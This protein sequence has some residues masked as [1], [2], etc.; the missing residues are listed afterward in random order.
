MKRL[1]VLLLFGMALQSWAVPQLINYQGLLTRPDGSSLDTVVA[2]TFKLYGASSG[3][4]ALWTET[5]PS[6]TVRVGL[7]NALLG[8]GASIPDSFHHSEIWLGITVGDNSEMTP[9]SRIVSV[10]YSYRVGTVDGANGGTISGD[11]N[12]SGKANIGSGNANP[13]SYAFVAGENNTTSGPYTT[14]AG[15]QDNNATGTSSVVGGGSFNRSRGNYSVVAGG[16]GSTAQDSNSASGWNSTIGGGDRNVALG[17]GST[18]DG[19]TT[20]AAWGDY[21]SVGGGMTN[22]AE[23]L[24]STVG[25][26]S[27]NLAKADYATIPGGRGN[28]ATGVGSTV[29]GGCINYA[30]GGYSVVAGGGGADYPDSNSAVG[31]YSTVGG[32]RGNTASSDYATVGGGDNNYAGNDGATI[33]GGRSNEAINSHATVSGGYSNSAGLY[34][35][36]GGGYNNSA[37]SWYATVGGGC[38]NSAGG[39][40]ATVSGGYYNTADYYSTVGGGHTNTATGHYAAVSGGSQ[41]SVTGAYSTV[42]GGSNNECSGTGTFVCGNNAHTVRDSCFIFNDGRYG[43]NISGAARRFVAIASNGSYF[44]SNEDATTGVGLSAGGGSWND[45]C[46]VRRKRLHEDVNTAEILQKISALPLHRWSYTSQDERIQHVG[47][48]AQDFYAAFH[49]GESDTTINTLDPDGVAL[50]AIQEIA[51]RLKALEDENTALRARVQSLETGNQKAMKE[52]K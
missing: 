49:L 7:F 33:G 19:G 41:N 16:G 31:N 10:G 25:G 52:E 51:K 34:A 45:L 42:A 14:V 32:G 18:V 30:R 13:G 35:T 46:D 36:V 47:P 44:Y 28:R 5:Q 6:C 29:G 50:A 17:A 3:G 21:A 27:A 2:M 20:N 43:G 37:G 9:R 40:Y 8:S 22:R 11:V 4:T 1:V 48:T 12:I 15:G 24:L 39:M 26:G 23:N 38:N